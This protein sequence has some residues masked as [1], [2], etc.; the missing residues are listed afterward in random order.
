MGFT[1]ATLVLSV[2]TVAWCVHLCHFDPV[3]DRFNARTDA[4]C[5]KSDGPIK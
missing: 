2:W 5:W 3:L 1:P 4:Q